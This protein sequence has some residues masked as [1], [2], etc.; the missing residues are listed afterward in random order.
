MRRAP[1]AP[2]LVFGEIELS[3][4]ELNARANRLAHHLLAAIALDQPGHFHV[5]GGIVHRIGQ[6]KAKYLKAE[7][8]DG[9]GGRGLRS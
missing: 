3:Y 4:R 9:L 1:Q 6:G 8:G 2:A 5:A 7:L